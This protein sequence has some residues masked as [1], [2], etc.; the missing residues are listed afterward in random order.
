MSVAHARALLAKG[1]VRV[2]P[3]APHREAAALCAM[4]G[5][6]R[7]FSPIVATDPPDGL[8][9]DITGCQRLFGG[10][11]RLVDTVAEAVERLGFRTRAALASTFGCA[12]AV[13]RF[14]RHERSVVPAGAE[15]EVLA[16]LP[17][18]AL[19]LDEG[20]AGAL[21]EVGIEQIG[22]VFGLPRA[23]LAE[24]FGA[25]LLRRL[26]QATGEVAEAIDPLHV[27][28]LP[29][30]ARTLAGPT[31]RLETIMLV[32]RELVSELAQ[33]LQQRES[34]AR[35]IDLE[36]EQVPLRCSS[37]RPLRPAGFIPARP[38]QS[39]CGPGGPYGA[40]E[41][42]LGRVSSAPVRRTVLLSR[43]SRDCKHLWSLL[44]PKVESAHLGFGVERVVLAAPRIGRLR[45][46]QVEQWLTGSGDCR[47]DRDFGELLDTLSGR[48]GSDRV[49]RVE[50]A[51]THIPERA[52]LHRPA[53]ET[54]R[55]QVS[56]ARVTGADRPSLLLARPE[57][58]EAMALT[59]DGPPSWLRW[60]GCEHT[61]VASFGPER[62]GC[63][64]WKGRS[65][66]ATLRRSDEGGRRSDEA[67]RDYFKVQDERGRW[68]WVYRTRGSPGATSRWFVHGEWG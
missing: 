17:V 51:E 7:R 43:P 68:L 28:D 64:W 22:H 20:T 65:D 40:L 42:E 32:V 1:A 66:E 11:R 2:E 27:V 24:R 39:E 50:P 9:L 13:A 49:T 4:A 38:Y 45:H 55:R 5:W 58:I 59:P 62:V 8:L 15:S 44:R 34:G 6:A 35:R 41:T 60:R 26:D 12:R 54:A 16:G 23:E 19:R 52:F 46:E 48:L 47:L 57:P 33:Q 21:C 3:Y 31:T 63:E 53:G 29:S 61:I 14:G 56:P 25:D 67:T 37:L 18:E 10:E 30:V 36:L